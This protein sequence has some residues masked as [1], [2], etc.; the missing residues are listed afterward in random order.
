[1]VAEIV[2]VIG[3]LFLI[4]VLLAYILF[5]LFPHR[6]QVAWD[7]LRSNQTFPEAI[8]DYAA[9][10][11]TLGFHFLGVKTEKLLLRPEVPEWNFAADAH[12]SFASI[13]RAGRRTILY[14]YTPFQGGGLVLTAQRG[15]PNIQSSRFRTQSFLATSAQA[16]FEHHRT[17]LDKFLRLGLVPYESYT[18]E[19]RVQATHQFYDA[20]EMTTTY[21]VRACFLLF[22]MF[23]A[24]YFG[25]TALIRIG[26]SI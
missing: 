10:L 9:Q 22:A 4:Y 20:S 7:S 14:F 5:L 3:C 25:V 23:L 8:S 6:T 1:M 11:G 17:T 2:T 16:L 18:P 15:F 26:A 19:T 24:V 12:R 13:A 21:R